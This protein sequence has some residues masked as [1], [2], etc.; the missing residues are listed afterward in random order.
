MAWSAL[1]DSAWMFEAAGTDPGERLSRL[2]ELAADLEASRIAEARDIVSSF[3][4]LAVHFDPAHGARVLDWLISQPPPTGKAASSGGKLIEVP[5]AYDVDEQVASALD[6]TP[7]EIVRLHSGASYTVAA[8][9]FSPGFPYLTGLPERLHLP[10]RA[11]PQPVAAG[12]V[13]IAGKQAGIYPFDS[14]GGWHVL[15][16]TDLELFD[17][18]R[19]EPALLKP[20]DCLKFVPAEN[21]SSNKKIPDDESADA[22]FEVLEPG[23]LATVQDSGR[24]GFQKIGVSPGGAADPVAARVANLLAGN[25]D[26]AALLECCMSGPVLRFLQDVRVAGIGWADATRSR[27]PV[28]LTAGAVL[29]LRGRMVSSYGYLAIAG[30]IDVPEILGSRATDLRAGF[31]GWQGR[32]LRA[33]DR[34]P[35]G[36]P[37]PGPQP[38]AWR[39][40]CPRAKMMEGTLELRFLKGMQS[41]WFTEEALETFRGSI[42]Q[43]SPFSDRMGAR[44]DGPLLER[45]GTGELISQPVVAGSVQVPPDGRP[46]VLLAERQTIGGYPQIGHIISADVPKLARALPG[47]RLRFREVSHDEARA[48]WLAARR[49]LALLQ[50]GLS[51]FTATNHYQ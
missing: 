24:Q 4:T 47:T 19:A 27:R 38:G 45:A 14:Q 51:F 46:I 36:K 3:E 15:G 20:G 42:Y 48:A 26:K 16:R 40:G 18:S 39:V 21:S 1:G 34:L 11:T 10:R 17:P 23:V 29:D 44:L 32:G 22:G 8:V 12:S 7:D 43:L 2:L 50:A 28:D 35:L 25:P 41:T 6:L 33:G 9:G 37:Q 5:V 31:G 13:A 30:G 49:E